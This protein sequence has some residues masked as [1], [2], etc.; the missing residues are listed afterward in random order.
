MSRSFSANLAANLYSQL[1]LLSEPPSGPNGAG[2]YHDSSLGAQK[3]SL[4]TTPIFTATAGLF[5][6]KNCPFAL[7]QYGLLGR[8]LELV[9]PDTKKR[10]NHENG[11]YENGYSGGARRPE[12]NADPRV[13]LNGNAP[14]SAFICGLQGSGKSHT[15]ACMLGLLP[16]PLFSYQTGEVWLTPR[17]LQRICFFNLQRLE[18]S[19]I[20][21]PQLSFTSM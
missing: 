17:T 10:G 5:V 3:H 19:Q 12:K 16:P 18:T 9:D 8:A 15:L 13:F 1:S 7:N 6:D 21:S 2:S 11:D 14:W 4:I 20:R